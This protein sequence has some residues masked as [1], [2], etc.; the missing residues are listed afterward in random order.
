MRIR[1]AFQYGLLVTSMLVA[2]S[3][4]GR[5]EGRQLT[6]SFYLPVLF[7]TCEH[8]SDAVLEEG[9][10]I[11]ARLP[12][13]RV[14]QFT[15]FPDLGHVEPA[16]IPLRVTGTYVD[17]GESFVGKLAVRPDGIHTVHRHIDLDIGKTKKRFR[18]RRDVRNELRVVTLNC[19][20]LC[21][22]D[23]SEGN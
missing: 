13:K 4:W 11:V 6:R 3:A 7:K 18:Y 17:S 16:T 2:A 20:T 19:K 12:T 10:H 14:F 15:Y 1:R 21:L 22:T 8:I 9:G 23:R 5:S